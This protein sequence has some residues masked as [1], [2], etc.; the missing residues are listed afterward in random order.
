M[1]T[2][3]VA[4]DVP[5]AFSS[6]IA[7]SKKAIHELRDGFLTQVV[8]FMAEFGMWSRINDSTKQGYPFILFEYQGLLGP[9]DGHMFIFLKDGWGSVHH[10]N[11]QNESTNRKSWNFLAH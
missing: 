5:S 1:E 10:Y 9:H 4:F 6:D 7:N 11:D 3:Q 8:Q 2:R